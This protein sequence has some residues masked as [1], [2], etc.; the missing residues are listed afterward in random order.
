MDIRTRPIEDP[1]Y[2]GDELQELKRQLLDGDFVTLHGTFE[3]VTGRVNKGF[4]G[5][6]QI[7]DWAVN[8]ITV[9]DLVPRVPEWDR[10]E[11][12]IDKHG[13][14]W[15]RCGDE[16]GHPAFAHRPAERLEQDFGPCTVLRDADGHVVISTAMKINK[17]TEDDVARVLGG[18]LV[19]ARALIQALSHG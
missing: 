4:V 9:H 6:T 3:T 12:V 1:D 13:N 10:S 16:Y 19:S 14:G 2:T 11:L 15:V 18:S 17:V 8:G 5:K 7:R